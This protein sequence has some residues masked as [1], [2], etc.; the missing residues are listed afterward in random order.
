[1]TTALA[2]AGGPRVTVVADLGGTTLRL[3]RVLGGVLDAASVRRIPTEGLDR[4]RT[5]PPP[6]CSICS[7][8]PRR[9]ATRRI[10]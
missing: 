9:A 6:R 10:R 4:H 2:G 1:M 3:G 7:A 8:G 5:L